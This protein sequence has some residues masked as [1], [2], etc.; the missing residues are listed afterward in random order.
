VRTSNFTL[1][2]MPIKKFEQIFGVK[3]KE[4]AKEDEQEG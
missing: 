3:I 4:N 2:D 1:Q